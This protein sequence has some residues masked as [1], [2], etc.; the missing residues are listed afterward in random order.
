MDLIQQARINQPTGANCCLRIGEI[1]KVCWQINLR[2]SLRKAYSQITQAEIRFKC[3]AR[4]S[5]F[6]GFLLSF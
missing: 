5:S 2:N 1:G 3:S 6:P 4:P